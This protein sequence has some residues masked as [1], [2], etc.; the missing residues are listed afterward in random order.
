MTIT[1]PAA[2]IVLAAG[3]GTRMRSRT[4]KML[5]EVGGLSL[6]GHAVRVARAL[7]PEHLAVVVG[8]GR[9]QVVPHLASLDPD[10]RPVVQA[11]QNG[12]GHAVRVAL[13]DLPT[14]DGTVVVTY[15]D[16]PLLT[17]A[18]LRDLVADHAARG[19]AATVLSAVAD[20]PTGYGRVL[21]DGAGAVTGIVEHRDA[22]PEQRAV[23]EIN[24]GIYAF[25]AR[26][27][28]DALDRVQ[29]DND[30]GEEYLTDVLG[31]LRDRGKLVGAVAARDPAD[32]LGVN[33]RVQLAQ[34]HRIHNDRI[35]ADWMRAGVTVLDPRTTWVEAGVTLEPDTTLYPGTSLQGKTTVATGARVGPDTT[36]VDTAVGRDAGVV[37]THAEGARIG[38]NAEV[39]PFAYLRPGTDLADGGKIGTFVETK[40]AEIGPGTKVPHLAY[41]GDATLG[42]GTNIGAGTIFANY[43]GIEKHH[44]DVGD[45]VFVGSDSVLVAPRTIASGSYVAAG[46]TVTRDVEPGQLAVARGQQRNIDGWVERKRPGTATAEAARASGRPARDTGDGASER[47]VQ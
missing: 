21:R 30:Q 39:G 46:S 40:K 5:H 2:V 44:T 47:N 18:T 42:E 14:L 20:D 9:D 37:R 19:A 15:G 27:L 6:V 36:L 22:T 28:A 43:D 7:Q 32:I 26:E 24:S 34:L 8:H 45:A 16:V 38:P 3:E 4:P 1:P 17:P 23:A 41:V 31:I 33:D 35:L 11:E 13:R 12:T 29:T 25:E 10:A